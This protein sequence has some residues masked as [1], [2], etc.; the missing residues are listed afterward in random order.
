MAVPARIET[1]SL[2]ALLGGQVEPQRIEGRAVF[3]GAS[4]ATLGDIF[5]TPFAPAVA[6]VEV[7][8]TLAANLIDDELMRTGRTV[9]VGTTLLAL[10]VGRR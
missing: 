2:N 9:W 6:G 8:G 1:V 4:A 7:L 10:A 5:A 3:I